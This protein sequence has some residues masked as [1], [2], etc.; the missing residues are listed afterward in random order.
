MS[1]WVGV[2]V[3]GGET[4]NGDQLS[5]LVYTTGVHDDQ[6]EAMRAGNAKAKQIMR[7]SALVATEDASE[8]IEAAER[9]AFYGA[10][11]WT[12]DDAPRNVVVKV[13]AATDEVTFP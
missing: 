13:S 10:A 7:M 2:I 5:P 3:F 1:A 4:W 8:L 9:V 11:H 12:Y 6:D